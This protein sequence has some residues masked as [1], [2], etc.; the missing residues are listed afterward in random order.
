[1]TIFI[2]TSGGGGLVL[3][4]VLVLI[5][6]HGSGLSGALA[7]VLIALAAVVVLAAVVLAVVIARRL[8]PER[9]APQGVSPVIR[10]SPE[11]E[12]APVQRPALGAPTRLSQDQLEQLAEMIRRGRQPGGL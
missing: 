3:L 2:R 10:L 6:T 8:L 5:S 9:A 12:S 11:P 4:A 1:V 7:V